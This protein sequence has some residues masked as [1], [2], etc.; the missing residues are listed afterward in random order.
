MYDKNGI[1]YC[2][3]PICKESCPAPIAATCKAGYSENINNI[4]SN[5]C[6]CLPGLKGE[7]CNEKIFVDFT[8]VFYLQK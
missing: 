4:K 8:Y 3:D 2:D 5:I 6:E 7:L 1:L